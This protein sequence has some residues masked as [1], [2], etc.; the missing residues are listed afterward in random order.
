MYFSKINSIMF[1]HFLLNIIWQP[2]TNYH[3][4]NT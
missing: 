3:K 1:I 2:G 4:S